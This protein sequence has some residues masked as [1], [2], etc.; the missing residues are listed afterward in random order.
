MRARDAL[1]TIALAKS[2]CD[3]LRSRGRSS[4]SGPAVVFI[5]TRS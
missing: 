5:V 4:A 3:A 2:S 1:P